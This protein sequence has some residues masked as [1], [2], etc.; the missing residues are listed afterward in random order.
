MVPLS[1]AQSH[2][3]IIQLYCFTKFVR[4]VIDGCSSAWDDISQSFTLIS[5]NWSQISSPT[6][7]A[8]NQEHIEPFD[9]LL[10]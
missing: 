8:R 10:P 6:Q 1:K 2:T 5:F 4:W 9:G 7:P 3:R